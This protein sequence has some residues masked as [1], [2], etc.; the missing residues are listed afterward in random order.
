MNNKE[1]LSQDNNQENEFVKAMEDAPSF[2]EMQA[3][4]DPNKTQ[5]STSETGLEGTGIEMAEPEPPQKPTGEDDAEWAEYH[6]SSEKYQSDVK[7]YDEAKELSLM[8]SMPGFENSDTGN[9]STEINPKDVERTKHIDERIEADIAKD[10]GT[11]KIEYTPVQH[12]N[13]AES[14]ANAAEIKVQ[15]APTSEKE[16]DDTLKDLGID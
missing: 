4:Q 9:E 15:D 1:T 8:A 13:E 11:D 7:A 6:D 2:S 12:D 3:Q 16:V 14:R 5:G 10:I